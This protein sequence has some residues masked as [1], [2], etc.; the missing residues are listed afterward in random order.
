MKLAQQGRIELDLEDTAATHTTTVVFGSFDPVF[1]QEMPDHARQYSNHTA[2]SAP[3]SL[4]ASNQDA[5]IDD[6]KGWTLVT[7]ERTRKPKPQAIKQKGEQGRKHRRRGNRK[8]QR[9]IRAAKPIYA[10]EPAE[11]KPR[12]PVSL[13]EYFPEDFFQHCTITACHMV[14]VE[15]E[16]PS[17]GKIVAAEGENTLTPEEGLPIHFSIEEALQLPKKIR[18]ALA[19][20]LASP[21]DH[22]VQESKNEGLR[23]RPHECA[24]C[25][26]TEDTIHFADE[27]LLLGSKPHNR[28]LFVSGYVREHKV[29]R[30]LVDG[31]S[32]INIMPKSTMTAIGI[33]VDELSLS[34]LLIQGFNQGGQRAMGMIRVEMTI[35]ELKS[36]VMFHVIDARTSYGLLLGR[37]WIHANGVVPS[38]LHQCL[39]FY[40]ERVK[41]IYGDTKPFTEA[42]S[43]FADAKFYINEDTVPETL[44][45]EIKSMSKAAPKKQEWQA[46]PKKQ[47]EEAMPSSS[48]NDDELS[49]PATTRGSRT[50]SNGPSVPVFRYIPTSRRKNGQSP[51]ETAAS[52]A[53]AQRHIDNVKLLKKNAVLPLT[54]LGDTKVAKPSQGFIKC[55]PKGVEPSFLPTK[56]TE[57]GFDPNAYKLMS[58]AGYNFT[59][60]ANLG[61]NDLNTVKDNERDLTKTQK[62]LEK[63]G[64][65]VSNNKAGLGFTPNAPVKISSK[66]K[67]ASAQHISVHIIQDR[68]KPQPAPRTSVFDRMNCSKPRVSAPKLIGGQNKTSVF[69]RLNTLVS[70]GSVFKRLS[71]PKKQSNTTSF[72]P[73][74]SVMERLGEAKEPSKR[75]KTTPEVE[76]IDRLA[77]KDGVRSSIP[78]RMKRQAILEVDTV[79][80]LKVKRRTIIHTGQSSCQ[81]AREVNTEEEAQD[82]FHITIQEGEEDESLEEDVIAAPSQLEDGGQATVDDLKELNLGTSEE[83]KPIFVSALLSAGEI[84][85]Y[86]QLLLEFKDVFA[87]TYKEMPGLDPII[88]VH[89]LA[90]KPGTRPVKQTQR[91]YRSELIPQ[92]EAEIDKLIE[93]GFIREVQYPKW[94]SNIVIVLKKSG[95]IRVCVDFRDLNNACPKDDFPLPI[96]EIMV[97]AT[98]GHEALSFMDGSSGYNQIRMALEDE[99]LTAFRTPKGIYCYK[100]MPFGLKNA[101]ATY[102][103]AMQKIFNDML[104]KNVE[105]YV[106]DVVVKTKKRSNHLKDLRVVFER[107]RKY[108]LKM[109]PLKCAFGVTSG[110]FLGFIVKHRGIEVDQSKIKA[111]QSMPEPRNLHELKSLQGRLAFIRRFISNLAGRCQPFSRLMKKDVSFV[112]DKACNNAFESI[113]KYLSS[114]PV[115]GAP[116]P[117]KPLILYIA[118]QE[119]SVG[120]LLAQEN[121]A[122]KE[123]ALYYLSRTLT[124]AELNYSPIE[125]MCL[126]LMFSIQKLRHYMHA[127]TIH[128]VAK[129]DPVKYVMSKPVL[130]GRL[131]KWALLLNQYE[132]IYVS[133]KA[134]KGQALA[135]FL[136]DHPIP[137]DW[138]ISDDLPDEEVFCIDIFPTWTMFFDGSARADG[139]G[140]G[141][142][143]MS[144]QR[145]VLPYSF[146]L[147]E[148]CSNNVA[149]YQAL[150]LGLQMAINMEIAALEIYGDSKLIINQLLTEYEVR[151]D[152]L[153][154]YFRLATQLLQRFEA[155]TLEHVPRKENQMADALA[156]LASSMT[157]GEDEATNVPVC[158]RWVIPLVTEM[159]LSDTNVISILPVNVEEWRQPLINYL[160]HGMLPDD[161]KHRSEIRRRAHRFLYYKGTLYRRSFEGVLLRCLGE[162]EANQAMEEA[163]SGICG[164]HQSGPKLHFQLKRMG[165]Y[166]PS[167]VKDCLEYAKRC[168]ACQFHAN[169]IHQPPEPLHPTATS[170][171]FDAWGLDVVGPIAP[172][173]STG[174]AYILAATDYF[175]KW[176]EAIPLKEVKKETVV[177]FIKGHIIHRYGV[178]RYIV[179]DNGKQFSNRLMD[180]LCEKYR[181]K[182][183]KSSMYHAPANGLAEAFNKTLCNLLKKVIGRTKKDW[184]ERIGEALWAYRTTYRTPTQATPYSLVYGVE[185]VLPLESQIPSLRMAIQEGL[186]DEENAKLRLQELEAL[187]EKRLEAQQHLECYQARLSKAF[188]K[189]V[190]PRSFQMGDLVLSL[191][192]PIITTHKTKSKFT[193]KWDRPYVVQEVYTNGAY[194]IMAED[195]LKIGPINGRF[196]KR[197]YP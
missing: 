114:P 29:S 158:Q 38:T 119:S 60:S 49:K 157:L 148:L 5:P 169:F 197:Y 79:G 122:Q 137:A 28:P 40:Q 145:Q 44:P 156:N 162:E 160:E 20:V 129:A 189:K 182:Q 106:D 150:I 149:E 107:L 54:Q 136:A 117:G 84:E 112:W 99:E 179:T 74:Q 196:L 86:Y 105:C 195:G 42:E 159:V 31:G 55:L 185:A 193:S 89:H 178:P 21:N 18:R 32:A 109:N 47:E 72:P 152:D 16:E 103:R 64:Y 76:E 104:H 95:Q 15:M 67:N 7:Y 65:G 43:H 37:P 120:A 23:P 27:D 173:S 163:H 181:F 186:T 123:G 66:A 41:V 172:K 176:A 183:H 147:S 155:V 73:R 85:K 50:T 82:I 146:Q 164:A 93:A 68:E 134:I 36:S 17:K 75:R 58:K 92:I 88:A 14:E 167:M 4:G 184:H 2:H 108:N 139:A 83:P 97:D 6:D 78:S 116:V 191:R 26:A 142:V 52:K 124:D 63:H 143:F 98:T 121:E 154:P 175:S 9:N 174:E 127:Y 144:P 45:K 19:T 190:L 3:P 1:L 192:R 61:K 132:I 161:P 177:C 118:A 166:W 153:V 187:D 180:E 22:E 12:I 30:M 24:T 111:I 96:I 39:K 46:M 35:G 168:Q 94:I 90:V 34:R 77:E 62:K 69:K 8:P 102:Q 135:D 128:L 33:K 81:L 140:A 25:Y 87:W 80:S 130:T 113:K 10:G 151:K 170:W 56:R 171:P 101:G 70:R 131:A 188:N 125:K 71:K 48:K 100:V 57:E 141:V 194:L 59:S 51:F 115:L 126:A 91:R 53:D 110:K 138:K 165:Y 13:H 133:A 11:Q